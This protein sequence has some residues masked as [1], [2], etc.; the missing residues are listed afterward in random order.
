MECSFT[1]APARNQTW[2]MLLRLRPWQCRPRTLVP[3][4]SMPDGITTKWIANLIARAQENTNAR[5]LKN[6]PN[7]YQNPR[8]ASTPTGGLNPSMPGFGSGS[9]T[10]PNFY[11]TPHSFNG[12]S[13]PNQPTSTYGGHDQTMPSG[14]DTGSLAWQ[15]TSTY[16]YGPTMPSGFDT[17]SLASPNFQETL[18]A[19]NGPPSLNQPTSTY[20]A[21]DQTMPS[22]FD[23]GSAMSP[24]FNEMSKSYAT[25]PWAPPFVPSGLGIDNATSSVSKPLKAL[26]PMSQDAERMSPTA[27]RRR[28]TLLRSLLQSLPQSTKLIHPDQRS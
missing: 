16:N 4:V 22:G 1:T 5:L 25:S 13:L 19:F 18:S 27:K 11:S 8:C 14:F 12:P 23:T 28:P 7:N 6:F 20:G 2:H 24:L 15:P 26:S 21:H 9:F 10:S 3:A 17:G